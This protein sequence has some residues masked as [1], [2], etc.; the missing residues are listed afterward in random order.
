MRRIRTLSHTSIQDFLTCPRKFEWRR[1]C[2]L[3]KRRRA[4]SL[5]LGDRYHQGLDLLKKGESLEGA[6]FHVWESYR[7]IPPQVLDE[8][9]W[10]V[11]REISIRLL[12]A[13][14]LFTEPLDVVASEVS[15]EARIRNPETGRATGRFRY[16]GILD[17]IVRLVD[18]RLGVLEQKTT[19][20][21]IEPHSDYIRRLRVDSQISRYLLAAQDAGI[22]A[23][24]VIYDITRKPSI[25]PRRLTKKEIKTLQTEGTYFDQPIE[26]I[27]SDLRRETPEMFGARLND[28]IC[29]QPERYFLRLEIPRLQQDLDEESRELWL[30]QQAVARAVRTGHFFRNTSAC[31]SP[32]RCE[33]ADLCLSGINPAGLE[34]GEVPDG[35]RLS[36]STPTEK[37]T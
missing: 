22:S 21:S 15:F 34:P 9:A 11:E 24:A 12:C 5:R 31:L 36:R 37:T 29:R 25:K 35:Y 1:V 28:H 33:F 6:I 8:V 4:Q 32:Y 19:S 23:S 7:D 26:L 16:R 20:Q 14:D 27:P 13:W 3:R 2:R 30:Q 17:G 10:L 18:G